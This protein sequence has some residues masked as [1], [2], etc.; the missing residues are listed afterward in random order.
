MATC[1]SDRLSWTGHSLVLANS[2]YR[3]YAQSCLLDVRLVC[4]EA[5][6]YAHKAVLAAGSRFFMDRLQ[7]L[8]SGMVELHM[9]TANLGMLIAPNDLRA[10]VEYM[11][12]GELLVPHHRLPH[13]LAL[14]RS[15]QV[16][17]FQADAGGYITGPEPQYIAHA[18]MNYTSIDTSGVMEITTDNS[19]MQLERTESNCGLG[20]NTTI[21]LV[22]V[23]P[24]E[25]GILQ[26]PPKYSE[27]LKI[28]TNINALGSST[29][30]SFSE[31]CTA[32]GTDGDAFAIQCNQMKNNVPSIFESSV[33]E[34]TT[35]VFKSR[36][37]ECGE[38]YGKPDGDV[39]YTGTV[40][41]FR[42]EPEVVIEGGRILNTTL[43]EH[44]KEERSVQIDP[45]H[46]NTCVLEGDTDDAYNTFMLLE[47]L[48]ADAPSP[49]VVDMDSI[50]LSDEAKM[51][52]SPRWLRSRRS[53]RATADSRVR[54]KVKDSIGG[55]SLQDTS[56]RQSAIFSSLPSVSPEDQ[57][58]TRNNKEN[59]MVVLP[60]GRPPVI[61]HIPGANTLHAQPSITDTVTLPQILN[62]GP[63]HVHSSLANSSLLN[64][65]TASNT[66]PLIASPM[67]MATPLLTQTT[68]P[69]SLSMFSHST[70][71]NSNPLLAQSSLPNPTPLLTQSNFSFTPFLQP[72][73]LS[74]AVVNQP[75]LSQVHHTL[76]TVPMQAVPVQSVDG[77]ALSISYPTDS[78]SQ[79]TSP[80]FTQSSVSPGHILSQISSVPSHIQSSGP[81]PSPLSESSVS[82][83]TPITQSGTPTTSTYSSSLPHSSV[84]TVPLIIES[85]GS[86]ASNP[87]LSN[88]LALP[89]SDSS[90][91]ILTQSSLSTP[92]LAMS[93]IST[94]PMLSHSSSS[95]NPLVI[96]PSIGS[97]PT[98][99]PPIMSTPSVHPS[100]V[101]N[102]S[103]SSS[104]TIFSLT[105]A[106]SFATSSPIVTWPNSPYLSHTTTSLTHSPIASLSPTS[107]SCSSNTTTS[108]SS[109]SLSP[110]ISAQPV[111]SAVTVNSSVNISESVTTCNNSTSTS[112]TPTVNTTTTTTVSSNNCKANTTPSGTVPSSPG[113]VPEEHSGSEEEDA[114]K[115]SQ[116]P[117]MFKHL[118]KLTLHLWNEH[119]I[120][121]VAKC[122]LCDFSSPLHS[123][124]VQHANSHIT[125]DCNT[126]AVCNK[127]FKTR[128]T[129][130]THLRV[131]RGEEVMYKCE[132]CPVMYSQKFNLIKH[133]ASKHQRD[134]EGRPLTQSLSCPECAFT[135][136]ADYKLKAHTVRRHTIDKPFKCN[137][138]TYATTE[139]TALA[140]HIRTHTKEKPYVCET[141]GFH[142]PTLSSLWRHRRSHTGEKPFE[143]EQCGQ[144]YA[145]SKRLRDHMYK[146]NNV[147][148]FMCHMCGYTC[149]RKDNLQTHLHKIHKI[150]DQKGAGVPRARGPVLPRSGKSKKVK[151]G[152]VVQTPT[153]PLKNTPEATQVTCLDDIKIKMGPEVSEL[154][155]WPDHSYDTRNLTQ[156]SDGGSLL[157]GSTAPV[158]GCGGEMDASDGREL[159]AS[160]TSF[161][162][163]LATPTLQS[164]GCITIGGTPPAL[165][166]G[167]LLPITAPPDPTITLTSS[168]D[169]V[170]LVGQTQVSHTSKPF[171]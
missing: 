123:S 155:V 121:T 37:P 141:C 135:T 79:S 89:S 78:Y 147:K 96:Q 82:I 153:D 13:V 98:M 56:Q 125:K 139:K 88:S 113:L 108:T 64:R 42:G 43:E 128:A 48:A 55:V 84:T 74:T 16:F 40:L 156:G 1:D 83:L 65:A 114:H 137:H 6:I 32:P 11:Y 19:L 143:C 81:T 7:S 25:Q 49:S 154:Q 85:S 73:V 116:C 112:V 149:R 101:S 22:A 151:A 170:I 164:P 66:V 118:D 60:E 122:Q 23:K 159:M 168:T 87:S 26:D 124:L 160:H 92:Q 146:H 72:S 41:N 95:S 8:G 10:V 91:S 80:M 15:L 29:N 50:L 99:Y 46:S 45:R 126:C 165:Q 161:T 20:D 120:G 162:T 117:R 86:S 2:L 12:C 104:N 133:L 166:L 27:P 21:P 109:S 157:L 171:L 39:V 106:S 30:M 103:S 140:K 142:A 71:A 63:L 53:L 57:T 138:C 61:P 31:L 33:L 67:S 18:D 134:A 36:P 105:S 9:S 144:Q 4:D 136:L 148:P 167:Y 150:E 169:G 132:C 107:K 131:H 102:I 69:S 24:H 44:G 100:V 51:T 62:E 54:L 58:S 130:K 110:H 47:A 111:S 119:E 17:G 152:S 127:K 5:H 77:E 70:V 35:S 115:C 34:E 97:A 94:T 52:I 145:D 38:V 90:S 129:V 68:C 14:V 75:D 59:W 76:S 93:S 158:V 163:T 3:L 28:D